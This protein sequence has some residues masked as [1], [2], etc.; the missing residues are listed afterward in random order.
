MLGN[1]VP[2]GE[3]GT[4]PTYSSLWVQLR[5]GS[6]GGGQKHLRRVRGQYRRESTA[7][8]WFSRFKEDRFDKWHSTFRMTFGVGWRSFKHFHPQWSTSVSSRTGKWD[9]LWPFHHRAIFA[10]NRQGSKIGCMGTV[11]YKP[12]VTSL[13][14]PRASVPYPQAPL[15]KPGWKWVS[16]VASDGSLVSEIT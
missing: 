16:S 13:V 5:G 9:E 8:K 14:H 7:R 12:A 2:N 6:R 3:I 4:F 11:R 10:F 15:C 1:G